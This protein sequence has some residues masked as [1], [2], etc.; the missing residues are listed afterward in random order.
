MTCDRLGVQL[1]PEGLHFEGAVYNLE[2][3]VLRQTSEPYT[4]SLPASDYAVYLINATKFHCGQIFH[5]FDEEDFMHH[6]AN[7]HQ[8]KNGIDRVSQLWYTHYLLVL[9]FGKAFVARNASDGRPPGANFFLEAMRH[10][11]EIILFS[12]TSIESIEILIC[13]ALY[14]QCLDFRSAAYNLI[15]QALRK[16]LEQGMHTQMSSLDLNDSLVQRSR[17]VWW[18]VYMLDRQMSSLMGLPLA[19]RDEE[20]TALLPKFPNQSQQS[21]GLE[22]HVKLSRVIAD[23]LNTVYST[24]GRLARK[25]LTSTKQALKSIADVTNLL[26]QHFELPDY[27]SVAG[28]SRTSAYLHLL[29]H[30]V[31]LKD[32][33]ITIELTLCS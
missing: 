4:Q 3:Q 7:F 17:K 33:S 29:H 10:L 21:A 24:E 12:T 2:W 27:R 26:K 11:P 15:G 28:V 14:L 20:V 16:A 25:F 13:A 22:L 18:T 23:I 19:V 6:F 5:L 31:R 32:Q 1:P 8:D 30:Q 9:A